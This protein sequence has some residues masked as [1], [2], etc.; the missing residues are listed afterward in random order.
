MNYPNNYK[1]KPQ[2]NNESKKNN[3]GQL[4]NGLRNEKEIMNSNK[5]RKINY[6]GAFVKGKHE[7]Y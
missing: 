3:I 5:D 4:G 7:G 1:L 2:L 6:Q